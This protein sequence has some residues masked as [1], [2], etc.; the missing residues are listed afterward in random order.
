MC[1][2]FWMNSTSNGPFHPDLIDS[3]CEFTQRNPLIYQ[4]NSVR[5]VTQRSQA[6]PIAITARIPL[7]IVTFS[8]YH[9]IISLPYKAPKNTKRICRA[10]QKVKGTL[11]WRANARSHTARQ[12]QSKR[13]PRSVVPL[14][15]FPTENVHTDK[16]THTT[17]KPHSSRPIKHTGTD[18]ITTHTLLLPLQL[19]SAFMRCN[20]F[21]SR[22]PM[23][24][25]MLMPVA[26]HQADTCILRAV[27]GCIK[28]FDSV[29]TQTRQHR[30]KCSVFNRST[31]V[32]GKSLPANIICIRRKSSETLQ[33]REF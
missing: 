16:H 24:T 11:A 31:A 10:P 26:T 29:P 14:I 6:K 30:A 23:V 2:W 4:L 22:P 17:A 1:A 25:V 18:T 5:V 3:R 9:I 12:F 33:C 13:K 15:P 21:N 32:S 7:S 27:C 20:E 28:R 8:I 19:P